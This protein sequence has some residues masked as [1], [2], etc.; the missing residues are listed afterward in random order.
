ML[1]AFRNE[2]HSSWLWR[3]PECVISTMA[4]DN[5][6]EQQNLWEAAVKMIGRFLR[7]EFEPNQDTPD[8]MRR[9][10]E[11]LEAKGRSR[12]KG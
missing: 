8:A 11:E 7:N 2:Q 4:N 1:P 5:N 9:L 12:N 6:K 10:L 3:F